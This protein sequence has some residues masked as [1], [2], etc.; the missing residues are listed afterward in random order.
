MSY[1]LQI[2]NKNTNN[3]IKIDEKHQ[4]KLHMIDYP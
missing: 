3:L 4:K 2:S 1:R